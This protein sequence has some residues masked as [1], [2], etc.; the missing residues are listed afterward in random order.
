LLRVIAGGARAL[1]RALDRSVDRVATGA[2][3]LGRIA[4]KA[5][6][7]NIADYYAAAAVITVGAVLFLIVVR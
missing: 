4:R 6:T 3:A 1:D 5:Q 2:I 7:G